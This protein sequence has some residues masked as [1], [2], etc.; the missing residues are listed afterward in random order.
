MCIRELME[1][2]EIEGAF[3]IK[4]WNEETNDYVT[5]SEGSDFR[6]EKCDID[7]DILERE[8]TYMY[9]VNGVLNIEVE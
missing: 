6:Y 2:F 8:I 7:E 3:H 5:L 1:Q 4:V 9:A